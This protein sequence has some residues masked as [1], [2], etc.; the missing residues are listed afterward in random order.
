M[1][2]GELDTA[3]AMAPN[4]QNVD[5][6][7]VDASALEDW[8]SGTKQW[9]SLTTK[10]LKAWI[11]Y[12]VDIDEE[13]EKETGGTGDE[14]EEDVAGDGNEGCTTDTAKD[15]KAVAVAAGAAD[16]R[17]DGTLPR[18]Q[19]ASSVDQVILWRRTGTGGGEWTLR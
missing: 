17:R 11:G 6:P 8:E 16:T 19:A 2:K 1:L 4:I 10:Q 3:M 9:E 18:R 14:N 12:L 15:G 5:I 7:D 13:Q